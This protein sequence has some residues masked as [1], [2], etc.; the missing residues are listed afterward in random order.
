[1]ALTFVAYHNERLHID[2]ALLDRVLAKGDELYIAVIKQHLID[3]T[4]GGL[5]LTVEEMPQQVL[6]DNHFYDVVKSGIRVG[7]LL[8]QEGSP[9]RVMCLP[10]AAVLQ[11]LS[12]EVSHAVLLVAP[13]CIA[14]FRFTFEVFSRSATC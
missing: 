10:L 1:M 5:F 14:V 6:T 7:P 4:L 8:A 12:E 2:M 11:C 3:G 13:E 9:R